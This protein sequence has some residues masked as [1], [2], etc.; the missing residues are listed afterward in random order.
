MLVVWPQVRYRYRR[1]AY[2]ARSSRRCA[3]VDSYSEWQRCFR[4]RAVGS[5]DHLTPTTMRITRFINGDV[6]WGIAF[7]HCPDKADSTCGLFLYPEVKTLQIIG[8]VQEVEYMSFTSR[9][10]DRP[11][12]PS[13]SMIRHKRF[14]G[15]HRTDSTRDPGLSCGTTSA[16][17]HHDEVQPR[18]DVLILTRQIV[19]S[20]ECDAG[21]CRGS[22]RH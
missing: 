19:F 2:W 9:S 6:I 5:I 22:A 13:S 8:G 18:Q 14:S 1:L 16:V 10:Y 12:P 17:G 7:H 20:S 21:V 11:S 4:D 3:I 15:L